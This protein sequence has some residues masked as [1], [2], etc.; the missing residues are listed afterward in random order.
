MS[1]YVWGTGCGASELMEA[2]MEPARIA[3]FVDSYPMG[4]TFLGRPVLLPE[5]LQKEDCD[6]LIIT[7]RHTDSI[8]SRCAEL[9]IPAEKCLFLKNNM[10]LTDRNVS[11]IRA[12]EILGDKFPIRG[13]HSD[14]DPDWDSNFAILRDT[15]CPAILTENLFMNN[16]KD[17]RFLMSDEGV[18]AVIDIHLRAIQKICTP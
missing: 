11:R 12:K 15:V 4:D 2:G 16:E 7:A 6:L 3:A 9:G 10:V 17:C 13:D 8:A 5:Q 14:G 18:Q 1:I